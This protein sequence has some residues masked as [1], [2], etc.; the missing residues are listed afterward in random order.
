MFMS[1]QFK[2]ALKLLTNPAQIKKGYIY[3]KAFYTYSCGY[4]Y[5]TKEETS[6][7]QY[8]RYMHVGKHSNHK[9]D[10]AA[11]K[12]QLRHAIAAATHPGFLPLLFGQLLQ[13]N[14]LP[15]GDLWIS[16]PQDNNTVRECYFTA[17]NKDAKHGKYYGSIAAK[18]AA[19]KAFT[20]YTTDTGK[21]PHQYFEELLT[22]ISRNLCADKACRQAI[23]K[24]MT[25]YQTHSRGSIWHTIIP[26]LTTANTTRIEPFIAALAEDEGL[27]TI[28]RHV[29]ERRDSTGNNPLHA[30]AANGNLQLLLNLI[31]PL[32]FVNLDWVQACLSEANDAGLT[33]W[34]VM[35]Q[36]QSEDTLTFND[37]ELEP[38]GSV[39]DWVIQGTEMTF[40]DFSNEYGSPDMVIKVNAWLGAEITEEADV[41]AEAEHVQEPANTRRR[42]Q[43]SART[44]VATA[45]SGE[46]ARLAELLSD[47][48][49]TTQYLATAIS[50]HNLLQAAVK[51]GNPLILATIV[52]A[53]Q[54]PQWVAVGRDCV[55]HRLP[56]VFRT[57]QLLVPALLFG[58]LIRELSDPAN[59]RYPKAKAER[60]AG[61]KRLLTHYGN[62]ET[63]Q[64][65]TVDTFTIP[66]NVFCF[67]K[68]KPLA[69]LLCQALNRASTYRHERHGLCA[70]LL[71]QVDT[72]LAEPRTAR[73]A[74]E[75]DKKAVA[76]GGGGGGAARRRAPSENPEYTAAAVEATSTR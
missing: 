57:Q 69:I 10:L 28:T 45:Q 36:A 41:V 16:T 20:D 61:L 22:D 43:I 50:Q 35:I 14:T 60:V 46:H 24:A 39:L 48:E 15:A 30:A 47:A 37:T 42:Q 75:A 26:Q 31:A 53:I 2:E 73:L 58:R 67:A 59:R 27:H 19:N 49:I 4:N 32:P 74:S 40:L 68:F 8:T 18:T 25:A 55:F 51:T 63:G 54:T 62:T 38:N 64:P 34:H 52:E 11:T 71:G 5:Y 44:I 66:T 17:E 23:A 21:T 9:I 3:W 29:L 56:S 7:K 6:D 1:G 33:P 13:A 70:G 65:T 72:L 76:D 12:T